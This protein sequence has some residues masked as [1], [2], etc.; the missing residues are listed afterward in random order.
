[1]IFTKSWNNV[2]FPLGSKNLEKLF[3]EEENLRL[4]GSNI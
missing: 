1:M 4:P 2:V 3:Q